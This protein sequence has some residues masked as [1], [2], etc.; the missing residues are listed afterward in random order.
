[1]IKRTLAILLF[2]H[3]SFLNAQSDSLYKKEVDTSKAELSKFDK[4]NKKAEAFFKKSPVPIYS[5][6]PESGN[7][8]GI[9]KFNILSL[10]KEDT[11]SKPSKL[12]EVFTFSTKGRINVSV[13][14]ELI[15]KE[16]NRNVIAYVNYERQPDY[17]FGIG[18]DVNKEDVEKIELERIK[19]FATYMF[20]F[21]KHFYIGVPINFSSYF[22]IETEPDSFLIEDDVTGLDGGIAVGTGLAFSYDSRGNR[23]NPQGGAYI[24][25]YILTNPK[26]LG[27]TYQYSKYEIDARKYF[28][29]W[30]K[31]IIALQVTTS[32]TPGN[33]PFYDL[34]MLGSDKQMRGY[35][36]GAYRDHVLVDSQ[37]EY[38]API[39]NIFGAAAWFG[40][41]R[42][43]DK[44]E[45]LSFDGWKLSY[46]AGLRIK[47]DSKNNTN[48]RIDYGFGPHGISGVYFGFAEA[49]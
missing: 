18:N 37:V 43:A 20:R 24:M 32:N 14:T 27:S 40:T 41:G 42:V 38:R 5:H 35:F 3:V 48:L 25:S 19:F 8:F 47:V 15:F 22:N 1:M 45:N 44:Y 30:L 49:F 12:S 10:S 11:I 31:H 9:T 23:Y 17:I 28:N 7:I 4:F 34:S 46:G 33:T 13:S 39:W 16:N 2:L 6:T 36:K 21:K 29:P 26:F